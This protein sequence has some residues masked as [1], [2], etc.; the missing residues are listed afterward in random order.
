LFNGLNYGYIKVHSLRVIDLEV[1]FPIIISPGQGGVV[2]VTV[3]EF[4]PLPIYFGHM[5]K[6]RSLEN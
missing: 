4:I 6:T 5:L 2:C 1:A 3:I